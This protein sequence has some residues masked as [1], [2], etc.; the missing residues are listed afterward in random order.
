MQYHPTRP[1]QV[2]PRRA[3]HVGLASSRRAVTAA[4]FFVH[5]RGGG[6][7]HARG[8]LSWHTRTAKAWIVQPPA[9]HAVGPERGEMLTYKTRLRPRGGPLKPTAKVDCQV[10]SVSPPSP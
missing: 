3:P 9:G 10:V 1:A 5:I 4:P 7:L 8:V 6:S 2:W